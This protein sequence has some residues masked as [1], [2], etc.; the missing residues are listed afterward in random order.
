MDHFIKA[1]SLA[2]AT[3]VIGVAQAQAPIGTQGEQLGSL[4]E[5][6][7]TAQ[8]RSENL[9]DVP[10]AVT[11]LTADDLEKTG[12]ATTQDLQVSVPGLVYN[13]SGSRSQTYLRGVG[14]N[15][16]IENSDPSVATYIDGVYISSS[17]ATIQQLLNVKQVEVLKGPQGTLYGRNATGGA[18]NITTQSPGGS[19][20]SG[21]NVG[22]GNYSRYDVGGYLSGPISDNWRAG[23]YAGGDERNPYTT[24]K[25]SA[26]IPD[27]H[28]R[29]KE[30]EYGARGK[31]IYDTQSR[32]TLT[33]IG[34]VER[35]WSF[36]DMA[37]RQLT[38]N[39]TG[40]SRGAVPNP[41]R[42]SV[43]LNEN[44]Q[45]K[46]DS[47]G[48]SLRADLDLTS[49][50]I[51]AI[52]A[53]RETN[54]EWRSDGDVTEAAFSY[55]ITPSHAKQ[56][57]HELQWLSSQDA[58]WQ[59]I[60]GAFA[61][62]NDGGQESRTRSITNFVI[63]H[64]DVS[65][66]SYAAF[67]QTTIPV[68]N[69]FRVTLGAR[70][71]DEKKTWVA[72]S[73]VYTLAGATSG[74]LVAPAPRS[75]KWDVV[76]PKATVDYRVG[77]SLFY[78]S[79]SKGF[80]SGVFN[81]TSVTAPGP[82]DP[83]ELKAYE[84]GYKA[85]LFSNRLRFNA[86]AFYYDYKGLQVQTLTGTGLGG[87][88]GSSLQ[89]AANA[90]IK[91]IE[92]EVQYAPTRSFNLSAYAALSDSE[93][94]DFKNFS[95]LTAAAV[96]NV[97]ISRDVSGNKLARLPT[98]TGSLSPKYRWSFASGQE[99]DLSANWYHNSG[100]A[101]NADHSLNQPSYDTVN[102][103][104]DFTRDNGPWSVSLWAKNLTGTYYFMYQ[105][106]SATSTYGVEGSP[107]TY[108]VSGKWQFGKH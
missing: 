44:V 101:F 10:I 105:T 60:A 49:S 6:V 48:G 53:Y 59:W 104:L 65:T 5:V 22:V 19:L 83:E 80:K 11:A 71:T 13:Q 81:L 23:I 88:T 32:L 29:D 86:A 56:W 50:R 20:E 15:L 9:Q 34:D 1:S 68:G 75:A 30:R 66:K 8:K 36:E 97:A 89:N 52:S 33:A 16:T 40:F 37:W 94:K 4:E 39:A 106:I 99:L 102:A 78:A 103:S 58:K 3:L 107:R 7:V 17:A 43:S 24:N 35:Y 72:D 28:D 63:S 21:V 79:Y 84:L 67:A 69:A 47:W 27:P 77:P 14:N 26:G 45:N 95:G 2:A 64:G 57:S 82:V 90:E 31:L 42:Y 93:Y 91:G 92:F 12:I 74:A 18:I 38:N 108:G 98:F 87:T 100:Y 76:T 85:D 25:L 51:V 96:G 41:N 46:W 54:A 55:T 61:Y 62:Q 70:Y 73:Q